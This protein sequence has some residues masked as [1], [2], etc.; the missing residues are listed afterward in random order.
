[1][2]LAAFIAG[3]IA[4]ITLTVPAGAEQ[5]TLGT[6]TVATLTVLSLPVDV[7]RTDAGRPAPGASGADLQAGDRVVTGPAGRALI[8][9]LDGSTVTVE[10]ASAVTVRLA[11][12]D[13]GDASRLRVLVTV[14]T[15][16]AR[17]AAWLS[18][19]ASLTLES[20]AYSA[21]AHDG[22]IGAQQQPNG[23]FVCWTRAGGVEVAGTTGA[24]VAR[25]EPGQK[26]TLAPG[27]PAGVEGFAVNQTSLAVTTTGPVLPL[28]M[29]PD[30][31]R[32]AGFVEPGIEVNQV[33][34]SLTA[35]TAGART[36]EVPAGV[37]GPYVLMLVGVGDGPFTVTVTGRHRGQE[38]YRHQQGG[39]A[40]RGQGLRA[41][42]IQTM[43]GGRDPR[44]ARADRAGMS[45]LRPETARPGIVL[46]SPREL[47]AARR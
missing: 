21:T 17:V 36:V 25:I 2:R 34:G 24:A 23:T 30:G 46:L 16:W 27:R 3:F 44:T 10:P 42:I 26:V 39:E 40:H 38:T 43:S 35:A 6:S 31:R 32:V 11:E 47:A 5:R 12:M 18:G 20:N 15:V 37:S 7:A 4:V 41:E 28:V 45:T 19:R 29:M 9:F 13:G 14:G 33:F 1:M 22:L 8:T